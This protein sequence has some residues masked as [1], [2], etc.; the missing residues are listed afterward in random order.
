MIFFLRKFT[1]FT[2]P[3]GSA[4]AV[5]AQSYQKIHRTRLEIAFFGKNA[6]STV[7][8]IGQQQRGNWNQRTSGLDASIHIG[9]GPAFCWVLYEQIR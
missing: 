1:Q 2:L 3:A 4:Q 8:V 9:P 7:D 6:I 5:K